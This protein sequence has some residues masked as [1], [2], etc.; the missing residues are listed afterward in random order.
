MSQRP[1]TSDLLG[2]AITL[3][4]KRPG[5]GPMSQVELAQ[6]IGITQ[7]ALANIE[8]GKR[9]AKD[10][11][12]KKIADVFAYS[13]NDRDDLLRRL[14]GLALVQR[15]PEMADLFE[16]RTSSSFR[17]E[18]T[19]FE[20]RRELDELLDKHLL[21]LRYIS[22][23]LDVPYEH[24]QAIR[25]DDEPVSAELLS[26]LARM[27]RADHIDWLNRTGYHPRAV[28]KLI[29]EDD[30]VR[31]FFNALGHLTE[32]DAEK[33]RSLAK[34]MLKIWNRDAGREAKEAG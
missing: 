24:L 7:G 20:V 26:R 31:A 4:R 3:L 19:P 14:R 1:D 12:L 13:Q 9:Q 16:R 28:R 6:K 11:L 23:I 29:R 8:K 21:G 30:D 22:E 5:K 18:Y 25:V 15:N 10:E 34:E 17:G 27:L 2:Q 32:E 33:M